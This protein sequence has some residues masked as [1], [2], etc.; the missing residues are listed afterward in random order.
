MKIV[1]DT[2]IYEPSECYFSVDVIDS[3]TVISITP[4][5]FWEAEHC[6]SDTFGD[7]SLTSAVSGIFEGHGIW[8]ATDSMWTS[9]LN[10]ETTKSILIGWGFVESQAMHDFLN[11]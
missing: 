8:G 2:E 7:H 6:L 5:P 1:N 9:E 11:R 4:I 3:E 10:E